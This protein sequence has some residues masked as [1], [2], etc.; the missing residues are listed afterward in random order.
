MRLLLEASSATNGLIPF[1][2]V[3]TF[4][5]EFIFESDRPQFAQLRKR[6]FG[7]IDDALQ[8]HGEIDEADGQTTAPLP[9]IIIDVINC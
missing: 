8:V 1:E 9:L 6:P 3:R 4:R 2:L 5:I 7:S